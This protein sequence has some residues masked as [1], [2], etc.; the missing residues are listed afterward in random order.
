[1]ADIKIPIDTVEKHFESFLDV[2]NNS[3]VFFSGPFGIGKT[4]FLNEFFESRK[5][6][7]EVFHLCPINYQISS[8]EDILE[9][10]KYDILI[11]LLKKNK[12]ILQGNKVNG[13]KESALLFYSWARSR[14][15]VNSVLQTTLSV[16]ETY[17]DI[18]PDPVATSLS[19][20]GRPLKDL[21]ELDKEFQE[22]KNEYKG[23]EKALVEKCIEQIKAKNISE[24]D[25]LSHLLKEKITLQK[26]GKRSILILDDLDRIDPEHVFRILNVLS[27]YFEKEH[28]N[29]FG[30]DLIV[31][32][33]DYTNLKN[34][35]HHKYGRETDFSGYMDKFFTVSPFYFDNKTAVLNTV[36]AIAKSIKNEEPNL[37]SAIGDSGYIKLFLLHIFSRAIN[38]EIMN[39][40]SLLKATRFQL[41]ELK[42]GSYYEDHFADSFQKIFDIAIKV[43]IHSFSNTEVFLRKLEIIKDVKI[44]MDRRMPYGKY[45]VT[46]LKSFG[47]QIP[48]SATSNVYWGTY[49]ISKDD[50][51]FDLIKVD[52][53]KE[54][55]LFYD[56]L[57]EYVK[58]RKY[59]KNDYRDYEN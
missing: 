38:S 58:Q 17:A 14:F 3:R 32:V 4:F 10:I 56:L 55:S 18:I 42:K 57:I 50:S 12:D 29:K 11:E 5:D 27:A 26:D 37:N 54:E 22:F 45:I 8:N 13:I 1:M 31:I 2:E 30:F 41:L 43:A 34:F 15:S 40:R 25:F 36:E 16:G 39:L 53:G 51:G 33:A 59:V 28:E 52:G 23:G 44:K 35:F 9:L 7:Y 49:L 6:K 21:L 48:D 19:K 20:L 24:T 47:V 46:M